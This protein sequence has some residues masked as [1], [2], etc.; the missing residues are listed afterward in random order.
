TFGHAVR[1]LLGRLGEKALG[2]P[3]FVAYR[4]GRRGVVR[5]SVE[6]GQVWV[7]IVRPSRVDRI[8]AAHR[9]FDAAGLP[10]PK[11]LGWSGEGLIVLADAQGTPASDVEW[12]PGELL[13]EVDELRR[14]IRGAQ[15]GVPV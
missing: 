10:V 6:G 8:V 13:D 15:T 4:P 9:A 2:E 7:K 14:R 12:D 5:V 3:E 11:L 1:S